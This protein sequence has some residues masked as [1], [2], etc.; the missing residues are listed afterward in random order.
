MTAKEL[1]YLVAKALRESGITCDSDTWSEVMAKEALALL[2][3]YGALN[4]E[5]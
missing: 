4:E 5:K 1:E 2:R 3:T